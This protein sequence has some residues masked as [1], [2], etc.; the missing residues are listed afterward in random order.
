MTPI[1][2]AAAL[3]VAGALRAGDRVDV[4]VIWAPPGEPAI[5][6]NLYQGV[7]GFAVGAWQGV[8]AFVRQ[9]AQAAV[10]FALVVPVFL[11]ITAGAIEFGKGFFACRRSSSKPAPLWLSSRGQ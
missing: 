9:R 2:D 10:E 7:P 11:L 1:S 5:T 8:D 3:A 6:R 4:I